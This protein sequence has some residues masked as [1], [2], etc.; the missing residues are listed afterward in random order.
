MGEIKSAFKVVAVVKTEGLTLYASLFG[1]TPRIYATGL[2]HRDG[3]FFLCRDL[4]SAKE[5]AQIILPRFKHLAIL[6]A[7]CIPVMPRP[8]YVP[9]WYSNAFERLQWRSLVVQ[10]AAVAD[11]FLLQKGVPEHLQDWEILAYEFRLI[12]EP[13]VEFLREREVNSDGQRESAASN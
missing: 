10:D 7:E 11:R 4:E 8:R 3:P 13:V 6:Q 2:W 1:R 5:F 12:G 9:V